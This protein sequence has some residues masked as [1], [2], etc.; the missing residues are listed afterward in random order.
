MKIVDSSQDGKK[1]KQKLKHTLADSSGSLPEHDLLTP[2]EI[3]EYLRI[4]ERTVNKYISEGDIPPGIWTR[5]GKTIRFNKIKFV[6]WLYKESSEEDGFTDEKWRTLVEDSVNIIIMIDNDGAIKYINHVP[7]D[8]NIEGVLGTNL[9][10]YIL[11]GYRD[12]SKKLVERLFRTGEPSSFEAPA[13][14][15]DRSTA[16][17]RIETGAIRDESGK[18]V[19]ATLNLTDITDDK[20]VE[21]ALRESEERFRLVTQTSM[22]AI[23]QLNNEGKFIFR[24]EN[25]HKISGYDEEDVIGQNFAELMVEEDLPRAIELFQRC[26]SGESV[27]GELRFKHKSGRELNMLF[28]GTPVMKD[29]ELISLI[30]VLRDQTEQ[31]DAEEQL[32]KAEEKYQ[33]LINGVAETFFRISFPDGEIEYIATSVKDVFGYS[34]EEFISNPLLIRKILHPDFSDLVRQNLA[35][36]KKGKVKQVVE[37]KIIDSEGK[38]RWI[39]QSS[40]E[41]FDSGG[42]IVALEGICRDITEYKTKRP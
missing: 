10:K 14:R 12:E 32:R 27:I 42:R 18:I 5:I 22:D 26:M 31:K 34:A 35:D 37:Y 9:F 15:P 28:T 6:E 7:P 13:V 40:R 19:N 2:K 23:I 17:Y 25:A 8:I 21:E 33:A 29:G 4:T 38:E 24:S 39:R 11:P 1:E 36:I 30:G 41:V 3:A 16:W 20:L